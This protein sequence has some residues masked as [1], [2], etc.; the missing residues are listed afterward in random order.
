MAKAKDP[1]QF[2]PIIRLGSKGIVFTVIKKL[3]LITPVLAPQDNL[4]IFCNIQVL[5]IMF[6]IQQ[7]YKA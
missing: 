5:L 7:I 1:H 4:V 2:S 3:N 6:K